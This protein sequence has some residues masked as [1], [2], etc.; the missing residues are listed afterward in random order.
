MSQKIPIALSYDDILLVP[1]NSRIKSRSEVNLTTKITP[2]VTL[3]LPLISI[4]M[5]DVT[6][7]DMAI[8]LGKLGALG[9]LHRFVSTEKQADMVSKVKKHRVLVGAAVGIRNGTIKRAD[10]L[11]NAGVDILTID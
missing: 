5:S 3:K 6:E 1:Q 7:I 8:A 10:A 9:F 11:V 4:N 2:R